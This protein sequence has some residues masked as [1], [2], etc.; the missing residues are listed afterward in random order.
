[1]PSLLSP[2]FLAGLLAVAVPILVHLRMRERKTSQPFPSLMFIRRVPHKSYR[3][4]TLRDLALFAARA[5]AVVLLSLAFARPFFPVRA[6]G[7]TAL[8]GPMGRVVALDVSASMGYSGV[9]ARARAAA[10]Q[11]VREADA[12]DAVGV[13]LFSDQA[14]GVA[15]PSTDHGKA[16]AAVQGA[17]PGARATRFAPALRLASDWLAA[18]KVDRREIVL[19]TDGQ[20]RALPGVADVTLPPQTTVTVRSVAAPIPDNAAVTDVSVE[21]IHEDSRAFGIVTARF[22]HQGPTALPVDATLEVSGRVIEKRAIALPESGSVSVTF[23]RAPLPAGVSRARI[24]LTGDGLAVDDSFHF[25]LGARDD[26]K[27]LIVDPSPF[28]ARALEIGDQPSFD[29]LRRSSLIAADLSGRSLVILGG[30]GSEA[31]SAS[32]S[33]ALV[34]FVNEGGGLL[35]T[36]PLAG[37]RGDAPGLLPGTWGENVSRLGDRGASLGFVDLDHPALF[38]FKQARGSDFSRARFLQYRQF[39]PS[40]GQEAERLR[41]LARFDDGREAL[42]ESTFG[43]GRVLA[44]TT[45]LDGLMSDLPVQPLFLP[46]I[47]ELARYAS[48]HE[49]TPLFHRVGAAVTVA[50]GR[51]GKNSDPARSVTSPLGR[52]ENLAAGTSGIEL[53]IPGFY[54]AERVSGTRYMVAANVDSGESDLS[55]LDPDELLAAIRPGGR[56]A[57]SPITLTTAEAGARQTCWRLALLAVLL[58]MAAETIFGNARGQR[59][60]P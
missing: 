20:T 46:L 52:K 14:Q 4:R 47:H 5:L 55:T 19:I 53:Q 21:H 50:G 49:D 8:A 1:M 36:A 38:A 32:S 57:E 13:L 42:V 45:P 15:P 60:T 43:R 23:T 35:A 39:K 22:I 59:A 56:A 34:R 41:V 40:T 9:F 16:L 44:F 10:E 12:S 33:S 30:S 25:V 3:R 2:I 6:G 31:L 24:L 58:L 29:I 37:L 7:G 51:K 17:V 26:I 11:A 27:T 54:E 18:L 48:A 28:T